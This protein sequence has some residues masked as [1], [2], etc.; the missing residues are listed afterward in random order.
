MEE[1]DSEQAPAAGPLTPGAGRYAASLFSR[2]LDLLCGLC[3]TQQARSP[4]QFCCHL[5]HCA[6]YVKQWPCLPAT[7]VV[8]VG[9][10]LDMPSAPSTL[11]QPGLR[12]GHDYASAAFSVVLL[13]RGQVPSKEGAQAPG[14]SQAAPARI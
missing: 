6:S 3:W 2:A 4:F 1:D 10:C 12:C 5:V 11:Q 9:Q 14:N 7:L 8:R 13:I